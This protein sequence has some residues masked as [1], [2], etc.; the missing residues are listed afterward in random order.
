MARR[1]KRGR[2]FS[3]LEVVLVLALV[4]VLGA[5]FVPVALDAFRDAMAARAGTDLQEIGTALAAFYADLGRMPA[6]DGADCSGLVRSGPGRNNG[7]AFLAVGE[8]RG[9]LRDFYPADRSTLPVKWNLAARGHAA[10]PAVNNAANH[11]GVNDPNVDGATNQADY[12]QAGRNRWRGPYLVRLT[13]DPWG[14]AYIVGIGAGEP[15]G[16]PVV[17][18]A[19]GWILSAGPNGVLDTAPAAIELGGDDVGQLF[20]HRAPPPP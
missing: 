18:D 7:L 20:H 14:H 5:F 12:P 8:G 6:C 10:D 4:A 17:P 2:G 1:H 15:G 19:Q 16:Q 11:L 13:L 3:F 9:D